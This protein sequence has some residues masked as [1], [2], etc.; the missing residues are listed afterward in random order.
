MGTSVAPLSLLLK[1]FPKLNF[2]CPD[3]FNYGLVKD[4]LASKTRL[5]L[6]VQ[7]PI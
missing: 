1:Q 6:L 4:Y 2:I 5:R 7:N 3:W